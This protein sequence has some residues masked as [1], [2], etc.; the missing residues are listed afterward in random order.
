MNVGLPRHY[1]KNFVERDTI[2][3]L[4]QMPAGLD[5]IHCILA[6]LFF[7]S[8]RKWHE[9][10]EL[11]LY[12]SHIFLSTHQ[13]TFFFIVWY[14]IQMRQYI[15]FKLYLYSNTFKSYNNNWANR[16]NRGQGNLRIRMS[17]NSWI[18][19]WVMRTLN[20]SL[21]G[22]DFYWWNRYISNKNQIGKC[23]YHFVCTSFFVEVGKVGSVIF[24]LCTSWGISLWWWSC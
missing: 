13:Q 15:P 20:G 3:L 23:L 4:L 1:H 19:W 9:T 12:F 21:D 5:N 7:Q 17:C 6:S 16:A 8:P 14:A 18:H 11:W 10:C 24:A 22:V 2:S